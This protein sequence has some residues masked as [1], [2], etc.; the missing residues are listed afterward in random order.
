MILFKLYFLGQTHVVEIVDVA[1]PELR[2]V[3]DRIRIES[4]SEAD[5]EKETDHQ[6]CRG[7]NLIKL[8]AT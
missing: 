3:G 8:D 6:R 4:E 5:S 2:F 1:E 7:R